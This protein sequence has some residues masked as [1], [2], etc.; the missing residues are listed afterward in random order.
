MTWERKA[1]KATVVAGR[2]T[3]AKPN[4]QKQDVQRNM[5]V[6]NFRTT[7]GIVFLKKLT[8]TANRV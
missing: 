4:I 2:E 1:D 6:V 7:I 3:C 5:P 8:T